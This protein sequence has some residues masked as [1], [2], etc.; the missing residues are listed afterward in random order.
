M[1]NASVQAQAN[2]LNARMEGEASAVLDDIERN[3]VRKVAR[4][5]FSCVVACYDKAGSKGP[6]D[7][8]EQ[9]ARTCQFPYQ[10]ANALLQNVRIFMRYQ[11]IC[12]ISRCARSC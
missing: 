7:A 2:A 10:Q 3:F 11:N 8:L 5:S 9:C 12:M 4:K 1:S 6:S